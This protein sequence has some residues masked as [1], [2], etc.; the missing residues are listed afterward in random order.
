MSDALD[1]GIP[2]S[3]LRAIPM[4]ESVS[5]PLGDPVFFDGLPDDDTRP[6]RYWSPTTRT[7]RS[8][9]RG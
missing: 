8:P 7:R 4:P 9:R 3:T 2:E 6:A 1:P 5:T